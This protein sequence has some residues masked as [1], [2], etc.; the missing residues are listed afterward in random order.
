MSLRRS[1]ANRLGALGIAACV[2]AG[3]VGSAGPAFAHEGHDHAPELLSERK[4]NR[5]LGDQVTSV[6]NLYRVPVEGA[7]DLFTHGPD[8]QFDVV[9]TRSAG[10]SPGDPERPPV[11]ATDHYQQVLYGYRTGGANRIASVQAPIQAQMRRINALLNRDSLGSGGPAADYKIGCDP[12][13]QIDVQAFSAPGSSFQEV[14]A[15]ARAAG[16]D[17]RDVDYTIF[18]DD[19]DTN[20]CGVGSYYTDE[21]LIVSNASNSGGGYGVTYTDC[22]Y[23]ETPMHENGH[24][25]GAVQ[26]SAPYS[27]GDGGHCWDERDVMCYAP[28]GG[29]LHQQGTIQRCTDRVYFDCG[30]DTYFDSAPEPG[31]YL[32]THWNLGSPLNRFIAF[33]AAGSANTP[34]GAGFD[35]SCIDLACSFADTSTDSDGSVTTRSWSFG[36]GST[37]NGS[38]PAH[39]FAAAGTYR[40]TLTVTDDDGARAS[41]SRDVVARPVARTNGSG[42]TGGDSGLRKLRRGKRV[43]AGSGATGTWDYYAIRVPRR[44]GSLRVKLSGPDCAEAAC[45]ADLDLSLRPRVKPTLTRSACHPRLL[46]SRE[47]CKIRRPRAGRWIVGVLVHA[48]E[49]PVRYGLRAGYSKR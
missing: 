11:C 24:N 30:Y 8:Q 27:T 2:L 31:E 45:D 14:V 5:F 46:G 35:L 42:P 15:G 7:R 32:A 34:P 39:R 37:G 22:W 33:G 23:T 40:V 28:D 48:G 10:L 21:R 6:D 19:P 16:F 1:A 20:A 47:A 9:Q 12:S 4:V 18:F 43:A 3:L 36:D 44:T 13:G 25:Q 38:N 41:A 49:R 29:N 17:D 26:Y